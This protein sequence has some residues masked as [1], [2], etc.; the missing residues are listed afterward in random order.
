MEEIFQNELKELQNLKE[1][2]TLEETQ[3]SRLAVLELAAA[4]EKTAEEKSKD[5][6]SALAQKD[7]FRTKSED[8]E[9]ELATF[10]T[11]PTP[12]PAPAQPSMDAME[13]ANLS[14]VFNGL[15]TSQRAKLIKEVK[16]NGKEVTSQTLEEAKKSEDYLLWNSSYETKVAKEKAPTPS[17]V[18]LESEKK[19]T[20]QEKL[21]DPTTSQEEQE[22][23]LIEHGLMRAPN[24]RKTQIKLSN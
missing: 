3:T 19:K 1:A 5:L 17:T 15:D 10:K 14:V 9:K 24:V 21:N 23:I 6:Q 16:A 22:K 13:V 12:S 18:Q 7:H 11:K 20:W 4:A 8:L 2:G